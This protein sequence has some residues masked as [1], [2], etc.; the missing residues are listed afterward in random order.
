MKAIHSG[1]LA[2]V[3]LS[4]MACSSLAQTAPAQGTLSDERHRYAFSWEGALSG[5]ATRRVQCQAQDCSFIME[6][7]VPGL[8]SLT[9][10]SQFRWSEGVPRFSRYERSLNLL[11]LPQTVVVAREGD[12]IVTERRGRRQQYA[13]EPRAVDAMGLELQLRADLIRQN[14]PRDTY[15]MADVRELR[16]VRYQEEAPTPLT[17]QGQSVPTRVFVFSQPERERET[18]IWMDPARRFLPLQIVHRDG[19]ET[20]RLTWTGSE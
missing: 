14:R 19:R 8:A 15:W 2:L 17:V 9:E 11:F 12:V 18:R 7:T 5:T 10:R 3:A 4:V 1:L 20:Y 16:E 6:A 13:D